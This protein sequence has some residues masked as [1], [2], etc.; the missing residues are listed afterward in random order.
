MRAL[1]GDWGPW[2]EDLWGEVRDDY[3]KFYRPT[4][5][6]RIAYNLRRPLISIAIWYERRLTTDG[7]IPRKLNRMQRWLLDQVPF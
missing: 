6:T 5:R 7:Y 2:E 1:N 4:L 3:W